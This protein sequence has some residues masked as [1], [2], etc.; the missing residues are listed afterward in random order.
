MAA[1]VETIKEKLNRY[2]L[3]KKCKTYIKNIIQMTRWGKKYLYYITERHLK[4]RYKKAYANLI[5]IITL[6]MFF[7]LK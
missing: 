3:I 1:K 4:D 6:G 2:E 7:L 5:I